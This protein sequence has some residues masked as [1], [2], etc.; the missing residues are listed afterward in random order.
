MMLLRSAVY[1]RIRRHWL[2][3]QVLTSQGCIGEYENTACIAVSSVRGRNG[4]VI[5]AGNEAV[6]LGSQEDVALHDAFN[7]P[8]V[9]VSGVDSTVMVLRHFIREAYKSKRPILR[10]RMVIH[11]QEQIEGGLTDV[12]AVTL[13]RVA[14][15]AGAGGC[16]ISQEPGTLSNF[17]VL[18]LAREAS[19]AQEID[20]T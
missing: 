14:L 19:T 10:P 13:M 20:R 3:V 4:Q 5:A 7:H 8:R 16:I 12:E 18:R 15:L 6:R 9:F 2:S 11:V 1:V 17:D